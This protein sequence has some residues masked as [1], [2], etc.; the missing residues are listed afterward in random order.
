MHINHRRN[1]LRMERD[2]EVSLNILNLLA[3]QHL[4]RLERLART[5]KE[6]EKV[7]LKFEEC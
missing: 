4:N 6:I 7:R 3:M 1:G 2:Q 5:K